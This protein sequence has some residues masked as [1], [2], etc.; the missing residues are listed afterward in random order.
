MGRLHERRQCIVALLKSHGALD[1]LEL[2]H[3]E[4]AKEQ[5]QVEVLHEKYGIAQ[6]VERGAAELKAEEAELTLRLQQDFQEQ[7]EVV[8]EAIVAFEEISKELYGKGGTFSP[9][10]SAK[11][12]LFEIKMHAQDSP[13][14][15][16]M[17]VFCFDMMLMELCSRRSMG[18]GFLIHD[19]H[20]FD[21][22]DK[23]QVASALSVGAQMAAKC[24]WQYI[25]MLNSD[26]LPAAEDRPVN[27]DLEAH[28]IPVRL[29]DKTESGGLFGIRFD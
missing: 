25:V 19:S 20:L 23:R 26:Q 1:Q 2:L 28:I 24:S 14:I 9:T 6:R 22:V 21:P 3:E 8:K 10:P 13:G 17:Q 11:G 5:A 16:N 29:S 7:E 12:P 4:I 27:F 18:P 15:A